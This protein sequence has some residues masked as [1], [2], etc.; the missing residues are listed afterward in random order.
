L[1][2]AATLVG[3]RRVELR[4]YPLPSL[5]GGGA[6][7]Q[8]EV[9]ALCGTDYAQFTGNYSRA[10]QP[11]GVLVPG[12]EIVGTLLDG[13]PDLLRT[14]GVAE[15]DRVAVE[16]NIPCWSCPSCVT[17]DYVTCVTPR[18]Y[19]FT[20]VDV[21]PA[22]WGGYADTMFLSPR[23]ILHRVP[24]G[25]DLRVASLFNVLANGFQWACNDAGLR[26]GQ[27]VLVLGAGQRGLACITAARASGAGRIITTGLASDATRLEAA[28]VL[29]ADLA[30]VV[31]D[32]D[33]VEA[34]REATGG[35]GVDIAIDCTAG[36]TRPAIDAIH[37]V[38]TRGTVVL[39]GLKHGHGADGFPVDDVVTRQIHIRGGLS[40]SFAAYGQAL[41]F[42]AEQGSLLASYRTHELPLEEAERALQI[43]GGELP[44]E[45]PIYVS[46]LVS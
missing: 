33:T 6:L 31:D 28:R 34:V 14:W 38:A 2:R 16:P 20:P 37:C 15:G 35:G 5:D 9:C 12:H 11:S 36:A 22:L 42:L 44:D 13:H 27:S 26:Y 23:S 4:E 39:S 7:L 41:R 1:A 45:H 10:N 40:A 30:I 32:C 19:G 8:V 29:G 25:L 43:L 24:D 18:A 46:L 3:P 21:P 17:G